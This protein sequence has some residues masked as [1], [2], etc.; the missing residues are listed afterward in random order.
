MK[1]TV[2]EPTHIP[3]LFVQLKRIFFR[4]QARGLR[5]LNVYCYFY[6]GFVYLS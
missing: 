2:L 5:Q 6:P 3:M 4:H 1:N